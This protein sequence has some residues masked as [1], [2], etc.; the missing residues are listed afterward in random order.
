VVVMSHGIGTDGVFS[1]KCLSNRSYLSFST[2]SANK[3]GW[4]F[5][6]VDSAEEEPNTRRLTISLLHPCSWRQV[7][8]AQY[9]WMTVPAAEKWSVPDGPRDH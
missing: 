5:L 9:R 4:D 2:M 7:E 8:G 6:T 1:P 3:L